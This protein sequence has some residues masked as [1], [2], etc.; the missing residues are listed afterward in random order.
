[1][2]ARWNIEQDY[3]FVLVSINGNVVSGNHTSASNQ[4][5]S[6]IRNFISGDSADISGA[7]ADLGWVDLTFDL[8]NYSGR[9]VDIA[10]TYVTDTSISGY[11]FVADDIT[12]TS[13]TTTTFSNGAETLTSISLDGFSRIDDT[14]EGDNHYYYVQLRDHTGTDSSLASLDYDTGVLIWYRDEAVD[15]NN[16][17]DHAGELFLGVVDADQNLITRNGSPRNTEIQIRDAAFSLYDQSLN[18][19]TGS[20]DTALTNNSV[21]NDSD[22][23]TSPDQPK[24]G[25]ILPELGVNIEV[26]TQTGDS[27][28][29]SIVLSNAS[30][31]SGDS[32]T[33]TSGDT[34][35]T[36]TTVPDTTVP[37]TTPDTTSTSDS[38]SSGGSIHWLTLL[39]AGLFVNRRYANKK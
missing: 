26:I 9:N 23:Y 28:T 35:T 17:S 5:Y 24:S 19:N 27:S 14:V 3:D 29:A 20:N 22:D 16:V 25:I 30:D 10:I 38:G 18:I 1:M 21:F 7:S 12:V 39:F 33:D 8:S 31:T 37:T 36:D 6:F 32:D 2:K 34:D 13:G 15:N 11:G 4:Y